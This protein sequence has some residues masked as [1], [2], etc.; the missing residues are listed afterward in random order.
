MN[1]RKRVVLEGFGCKK[2][3]SIQEAYSFFEQLSSA[4]NMRII[5]PPI[6]VSV[7]VISAHESIATA[8]DFGISGVVIW[9]ESGA[10]IHTWPEYRL[11]TLD[12]YSCK[13]FEDETVLKMFK[14]WFV[15]DKVSV[16]SVKW[17][18]VHCFE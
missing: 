11:I 17:D 8:T 9:L 4:I 18:A 5:V 12:V 1:V 6:I 2:G 15:P 14:E 13:P 10:Q 16:G 3:F 7:P